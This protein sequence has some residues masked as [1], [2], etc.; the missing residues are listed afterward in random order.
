MDAYTRTINQLQTADRRARW[1]G[2]PMA[3]RPA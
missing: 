3:V 1:S 2:S